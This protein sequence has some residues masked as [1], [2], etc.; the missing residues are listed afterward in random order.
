MASTTERADSS[1]ASRRRSPHRGR[2]E[3]SEGS[4]GSP[5]GSEGSSALR[6]SASTLASYRNSTPASSH[7]RRSLS[8][9]SRELLLFGKYLFVTCSTPSSRPRSS[10]SHARHRSTLHDARTF[11]IRRG[12]LSVTKSSTRA[13]TGRTLHRAPPLIRIFF[14]HS[15]VRSYTRTDAPRFAAKY[16][17]VS[18]AAPPPSTATSTAEPSSPLDDDDAPGADAVARGGT[19]RNRRGA[20]DPARRRARDART[21]TRSERRE[22]EANDA[23]LAPEATGIVAREKVTRPKPSRR[24]EQNAAGARATA[25]R[26]PGAFS[27]SARPRARTW[28]GESEA[29]R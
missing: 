18:P 10:S 4:E 19:T 15:R 9:T 25:A 29:G 14:P 17:A 1:G 27:S 28:G 26:H 8:L 7:A 5:G 12:G 24:A 16:A 2:R 11:F 23:I 3:G 20:N 6:S 22:N 13:A 21:S